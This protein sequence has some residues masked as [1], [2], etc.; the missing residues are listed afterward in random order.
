MLLVP[1]I[2]EEPMDDIDNNHSHDE[3]KNTVMD[4]TTSRINEASVNEFI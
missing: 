4:E 3:G 2:P 1:N